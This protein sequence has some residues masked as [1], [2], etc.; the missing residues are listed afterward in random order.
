MTAPDRAAHLDGDLAPHVTRGPGFATT[1]FWFG[2]EDRPLAGWW[3]APDGPSRSGVV[4]APPLGYEYWSTHRSLRTLAES[5]AQ[6]GW[7]VL[8]FDW[9]GTG[10]SAGEANDP[11]RV[12]AWRASLA[13]AVAT[14][15]DAGIGHM[16]M[17]GVR[18]G[19]TFALLDAAALGI[20]AVIACAPVAGK[21]FVRELKMLGIADPEQPGT[22]T[23]SGLVIDSGTA[24]DLARLDPEKTAPRGVAR[25][26]VLSRPDSD[27]K[28]LAT[29][30]VDGRKVSAVT[31]ED[32][33]SMLDAP[34]EDATVPSGLIPPLIEWLGKAPHPVEGSSLPRTNTT[35]LPWRGGHVR[36]TFVQIDGLA[37]V[38]SASAENVSDTVVLFLNSGSEPH[39]GPARA[40]V[41][42]A[43]TLALHG[44]DCVRSDFSGWGESPD[45]GH[46]RGRPYD[47]HCI[48]QTA[49]LATALRAHYRR[50]VLAGLCAGAWIALKAA[51]QTE[52]AGVFALNPQLYWQPGD[53]VEALMSDTHRRRIPDRR[54]DA[55]G[56]RWGW[57]SLL[58]ALSV[59]PMASRWLVNLRRRRTPVMLSFAEGDDG[60]VF[61]RDRCGRRLARELRSGH[62][63]VEE[64][65][66]IDH[67]MYRL[68]RRPAII[69]Q[70]LRFLAALPPARS[71]HD[72]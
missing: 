33:H 10:D 19:A 44:Y 53:P 65:P 42:Y 62:V 40:W 63:A 22:I 36:E 26:M 5:L 49:R 64:V 55:A 12:A 60:L 24:A 56:A 48:Q 25:T 7:H 4:I 35:T 45:E 27:V 21:R 9:D 43:R 58:D 39:I 13:H 2:P 71:G 15:R 28:L 68:W 8:R 57:W 50:V 61:L 6:A 66:G 20:D 51:Q 69:E 67:P 3:T 30:R 17:I 1:G 70:M 38:R 59:R 52:V 31:C 34:S 14:M 72:T 23:Y 37:A 29:L 11:G 32:I 47:K 16:A 18:L 54:R 41:E 46:P